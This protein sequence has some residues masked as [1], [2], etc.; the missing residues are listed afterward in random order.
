MIKYEIIVHKPKIPPPT[1]WQGS[2]QPNQSRRGFTQEKLNELINSLPFK[3]GDIITLGNAHITQPDSCHYL[4]RI[5]TD[6]DKL[7]WS[8]VGIPKILYV[9]Q[10]TMHRDP[11]IRW[12]NINGW[13]KLN[14]E[15]FNRIIKGQYDQLQNYCKQWAE[16][17]GNTEQTP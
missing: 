13:R 15:E 8:S 11:W 17:S 12:D 16:R 3:V 2:W 9:V 5:Q 7:E 4:A 1:V 14:D 6:V 10:C